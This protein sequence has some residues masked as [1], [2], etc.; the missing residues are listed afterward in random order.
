MTLK[1]FESQITNIH[2]AM[3]LRIRYERKAK[4][5]INDH[6]EM[7]ENPLKSITF[8]IKCSKHEADLKCGQNRSKPRPPK[9]SDIQE[10]LE[11]QV[12]S[13]AC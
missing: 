6:S 13:I 2:F 9:M 8:S 5:T 7:L 10:M 3:R 12:K 4:T 11:H 1:P